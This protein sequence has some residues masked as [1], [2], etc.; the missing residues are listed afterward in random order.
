MSNSTQPFSK[1]IEIAK[2]YGVLVSLAAGNN[3]SDID[4]DDTRYAPA[5]FKND[6]I[7]VTG[8]TV[9]TDS[10]AFFSNFGKNSVDMFAPAKRVVS[11]WLRSNVCEENCYA[12]HTGT[13]F[14]A[15]QTT[16]VAAL[17]STNLNKSD[18]ERVKCSILS[19]ATFKDF[20]VN[21]SR[22]AGILSGNDALTELKKGSSNGSCNTIVTAAPR[23]SKRNSG[24]INTYPN[25]FT[26]SFYIDMTLPSAITLQLSVLN[27]AG[28]LIS[29]HSYEASQ[30]ENT[31]ILNED[32]T[33]IK[34]AGI[35]FVKVQAGEEIYMKKV[36]KVGRE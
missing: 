30:G 12:Y 13:S 27:I 8:A 19:G 28:E 25:P 34:N 11:T 32:E 15:P 22:R 24:F 23:K 20:L 26:N 4:D 14:A 36:V 3:G 21:K 2:E 5:S 6:N 10:I 17:L 31:L 9:C 1:A 35:Y 29:T 7:I 18:W 16:A 33:G